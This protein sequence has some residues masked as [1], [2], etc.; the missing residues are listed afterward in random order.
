VAKLLTKSLEKVDINLRTNLYNE[1][2]LAGGN[3]MFE[4]FPERFLKEIKGLLPSEAKPRIF[5]SSSRD[6]MCWEGGSILASLPS[7]KNMW[8]TKKQYEE[9]KDHT[10]SKK[11]Y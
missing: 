4:G 7:F 3:T 8:I 2:V 11:F 9:Q 10:F 5:A 1:I 6:T